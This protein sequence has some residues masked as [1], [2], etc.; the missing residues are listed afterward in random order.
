MIEDNIKIMSNL[1]NYSTVVEIV[2]YILPCLI[3]V[4]IFNHSYIIFKMGKKWDFLFFNLEKK[5]LS[6]C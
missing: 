3:L 1:E 2:T 4:G 6:W 5:F